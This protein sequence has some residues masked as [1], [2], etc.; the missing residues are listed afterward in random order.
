MS[1][2]NNKIMNHINLNDQAFKSLFK[3]NMPLKAKE[4]ANG[5]VIAEEIP[6]E[7]KPYG[8]TYCR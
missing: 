2:P 7:K 5:A 4:A 6:A 1:T 8:N 3:F